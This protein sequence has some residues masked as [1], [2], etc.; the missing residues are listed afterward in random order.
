MFCDFEWH[1]DH[2]NHLSPPSFV[3]Y[4]HLHLSPTVPETFCPFFSDL[5]PGVL[6]FLSSYVSKVARLAVSTCLAVLSFF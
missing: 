4:C 3:L 5:F 2:T 1:L 6:R